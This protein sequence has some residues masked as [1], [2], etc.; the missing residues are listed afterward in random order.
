MVGSWLG[1]GDGRRLIEIIVMVCYAYDTSTTVM[2]MKV[3]LYGE[4]WIGDG[5]CEWCDDG[6]FKA[7]RMR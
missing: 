6:R 1:Y 7:W 4:R 3:M 2:S 5:E